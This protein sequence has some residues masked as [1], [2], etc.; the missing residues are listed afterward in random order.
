MNKTIP[1]IKKRSWSSGIRPQPCC[2]LH[3][4]TS[5]FRVYSPP[6]PACPSSSST[7]RPWDGSGIMTLCIMPPLCKFLCMS[8]GSLEGHLLCISV[9]STRGIVSATRDLWNK[10]V[11]SWTKDDGFPS[12]FASWQVSCQLWLG[13][14]CSL[15]ESRPLVHY[16]KRRKGRKKGWKERRREKETREREKKYL[17]HCWPRSQHNVTHRTQEADWLLRP[18]ITR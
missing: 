13:R 6:P 15:M 14:Q 11:P 5:S 9:C 16:S 10:W 3:C 18:F 17:G 1:R 7:L 12:S 2:Q 4:R 8:V